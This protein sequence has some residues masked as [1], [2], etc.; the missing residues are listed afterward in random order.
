M[1]FGSR[2]KQIATALVLLGS[3]C[4]CGTFEGSEAKLRT[5]KTVGIVSA[6]GDEFSFTRAGLTGFDNGD[7]RSSIAAWGLDDLIVRQATATLS[8][9]FQVRPVRYRQA[10][11]AAPGASSP[12]TVMNLMREDRITTL[13]RKE[14]S[15]QP[16]DAYVVI[17]KTRSS[18][19][20]SN[21]TVEGI[22]LIEY[23]SAI[24]SYDQ[25]YALYEIRVVDGHSFEVLEKRTAAPLE[26][27]DLV[28]LAGPS[29]R[30]DDTYTLAAGDPAQNEKAREVITDMIERSLTPTL[31]DLHLAG[32][33]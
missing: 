26:H 21:R 19:G 13:L 9:R 3:L 22:G 29:R 1:P 10:A 14:L 12:I 23:V 32:E 18:I 7:R 24:G 28:R 27:S 16:L 5:I 4:A 17:V 33:H 31:R 11:F 20:P 25:L 15:S 30:V 8:G 6:V 2:P